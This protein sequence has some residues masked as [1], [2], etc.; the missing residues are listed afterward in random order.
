M[1]NQARDLTEHGDWL[2]FLRITNTSP[3]T[4][5]RLMNIQTRAMQSAAFGDAIARGW[6]TESAAWRL[7]R[8]STPEMV[9]QHVLALPEPPTVREVEAA[10]VEA[11]VSAPKKMSGVIGD[12]HVLRLQ[13]LL[14][15]NPA[16][17]CWTWPPR[18]VRLMHGNAVA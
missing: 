16:Q 11:G 8:P 1:L 6:L 13:A 4:A 18:L 10:V 2:L 5:E 17:A 3:D 9:I 7:A 15:D 12:Q 14:L